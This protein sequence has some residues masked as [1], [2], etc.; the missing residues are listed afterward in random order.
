[1]A[2]DQSG[3]TRGGEGRLDT[4]AEAPQYCGHARH[5]TCGQYNKKYAEFE[6][7]IKSRRGLMDHAS[8]KKI[9]SCLHPDRV[10][11]A[12]MKKRYEEA[13]NI[14]TQLEKV[15]LDESQSPTNFI[16]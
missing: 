5:M 3:G 7:G 2:R 15:L 10:Q 1:M 12:D 11:D 4:V 9:L 8:Y 6:R 14:L 13:F 16:K